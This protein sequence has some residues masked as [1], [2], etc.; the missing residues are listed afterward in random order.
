VDPPPSYAATIGDNVPSIQ[1]Q[2][3]I[4]ANITEEEVRCALIDF[5]GEKC[6]YGS[7]PARDMT[8]RDIIMN[9]A[10]HVIRKKFS[11][12]LKR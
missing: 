10:F 7:G 4:S 3:V 5:V 1:Q 6:C 9:N 11:L 2:I 12:F 8:I